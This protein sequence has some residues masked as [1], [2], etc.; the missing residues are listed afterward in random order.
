[1][2]IAGLYIRA[3]SASNGDAN[4]GLRG[5]GGRQRHDF[6]VYTLHT[7]CGRMA[8]MFGFA[9]ASAA[10][11]ARLAKSLAPFLTGRNVHDREAL[12]HDFRLR[13]RM[14]GHLPGLGRDLDWDFIE[15]A[16]TEVI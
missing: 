1:M 8:S 5:A 15:N 7:E 11:S 14:W 2:R 16:T 9:G 6:L 12:W 10:G 4:G 13:N 3:C